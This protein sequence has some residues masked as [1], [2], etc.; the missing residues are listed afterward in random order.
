M[1]TGM[2]VSVLGVVILA[3]YA[4]ASWRANRLRDRLVQNI[5]ALNSQLQQQTIK[6]AIA[7][8]RLHQIP[9]KEA[10]LLELQQ[11]VLQLKTE[12]ADLI[13]RQ[14]EQQKSHSEK[15]RLW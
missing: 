12:N 1:E 13:A 10:E 7:D 11:A 15:L 14:Q 3:S 2:I 5:D 9:V 4:V 6:L 8:E